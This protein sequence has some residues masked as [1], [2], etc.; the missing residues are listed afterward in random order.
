MDEARGGESGGDVSGMVRNV[1]I[2]HDRV[3]RRN[4]TCD[5]L[6]VM[7]VN[8]YMLGAFFVDDP[9]I[10]DV[11]GNYIITSSDAKCVMAATMGQYYNVMYN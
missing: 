6:D 3:K 5:I 9:S 4:S 11:D 1:T 10:M 2:Y 7:M 8:R